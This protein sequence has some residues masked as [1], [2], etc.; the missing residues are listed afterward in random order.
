MVTISDQIAAA[1]RW[2]ALRPQRLSQEARGAA[3][4]MGQAKAD[5]E[6]DAMTEIIETLRQ[7]GA[8]AFPSKRRP[9]PQ[10]ECKRRERV[11]GQRGTRLLRCCLGPTEDAGQCLGV[12]RAAGAYG[13]GLVIIEGERGKNNLITANSTDT[14]KV[15]RHTPTILTGDVF[16]ALPVNAR[17]RW[18]SIFCL[19]PFRWSISSTRKAPSASSAPRTGGDMAQ[20]TLAAAWLRVS[21]P[22]RALYEP[23]RLRERGSIR[24]SFRKHNTGAPRTN[25]SKRREDRPPLS[26]ARSWPR[27]PC[28]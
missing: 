4:K 19:T 3:L 12:L 6:I 20:L 17:F 14:M 28:G 22:T 24:Q 15:W 25:R 10:S 16:D 23:S 18:P 9:T 5:H 8:F 11:C 21:V 26:P 2:L 7:V 1:R 13:A 27:P